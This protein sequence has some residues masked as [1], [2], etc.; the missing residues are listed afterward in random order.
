LVTVAIISLPEYEEFRRL[1]AL[2]HLEEMNRT[3]SQEAKTRGITEEKLLEISEEVKKE[4]YKEVYGQ[5][6]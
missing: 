6:S 4:I 3:L 2:R 1:L 5:S